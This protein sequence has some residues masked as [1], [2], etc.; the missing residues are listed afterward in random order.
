MKIVSLAD[1]IVASPLILLVLGSLAP[2]TTKVIL[3]NREPRSFVTLMEGAVALVGSA[4]L[5]ASVYYLL[6]ARGSYFA[7]NDLLI[8]DRLTMVTS[9]IMLIS[10][11]FVLI[12]MKENPSSSGYGYA[13]LTFLLLSSLVGGV[14]LVASYDFITTFLGLEVMSLP[15]YVMIGMG[16][17]DRYSKESAIKYFVLG[18]F[19]SAIFLLGVALMYGSSG[20]T[21]FEGLLKLGVEFISTNFVFL[22]G[23]TLVIVGLLFKVSAF[24]FQSWT[25][26]VYQGAPTPVTSYMASVMKVA[27]FVVLIR[28]VKLGYFASSTPLFELIQWVTVLTILVGNGGALVQQSIKRMLAYS[29]I[30]HS[31][32][33]MLGLMAYGLSEYSSSEEL[34]KQNVLFYLLA[35]SVMTLGA[36]GVVSYLEQK[37]GAQLKVSDLRGLGRTRLGLA[38]ALS[39]LLL[40]LGGIPP[41]VGFFTKFYLFIH[42]L[43]QGLVWVTVWAA[44]GSAMGIYYYLRPMVFMFMEEPSSNDQAGDASYFT[45]KPLTHLIA[46]FFS[47][48]VITIGVFSRFV[49]EFI[50]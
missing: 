34:I 16:H 4:I 23:V 46:V 6:T 39:L 19:A 37:E 29:S 36:F 31:G 28:F 14:T 2:I 22:M 44:V 48:V 1:I 8:F 3:G 18:S 15:V 7:F 32:Y 38:L 17:D 45:W 40:S 25:V 49:L 26:D 30:A 13:E 10:S 35:Y 42:A 9:V 47:I 27:S 43:D 12:L 24:P 41:F 21:S 33:V 50:R 5:T 20:T 11:V